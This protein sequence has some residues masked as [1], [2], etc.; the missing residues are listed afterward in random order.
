MYKLGT[1][2]KLRILDFDIE[3]R[4]LSYWG[5]R[6]TN[7]ITAISSCFTD[8]LGTMETHLLGKDDP[9]DMLAF[10]VARYNEADI[11]TG[12][13]I[14]SYDLPQINGALLEYGMPKLLPKMTQDTYHD[15]HKRGDIPASQEY[16]LDLFDIGTKLHMGQHAWRT[17]NRLKPEGI[18]KAKAR[19]TGDVYDHMRLRVELIKRKLLK[20]PKIWKP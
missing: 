16:L 6:P 8:D 13:N 9:K 19:C 7:E 15:L 5:E 11:V 4:P 20:A 17:A 14:R 1:V 2:Q 10:F 12:H 3:A 18:D